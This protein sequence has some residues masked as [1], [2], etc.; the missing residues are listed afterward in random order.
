MSEQ[1]EIKRTSC[2]FGAG[3]SAAYGLPTL[4]QLPKA[5][6]EFIASCNSGYLKE[7]FELVKKIALE[8]H[9]KDLEKEWI[10]YEMLLGQLDY[11]IRNNSI[12]RVGEYLHGRESLQRAFTALT[13]IVYCTIDSKTSKFS[14]DKYLII[15]NER[16]LYRAFFDRIWSKTVNENRVPVISTISFNYDCKLDDEYQDHIWG[17]LGTESGHNIVPHYL[18]QLYTVS[19]AAHMKAGLQYKWSYSKHHELI[20][21]HG[22][23]D[24]YKCPNCKTIHNFKIVNSYSV[25]YDESE[26]L[27]D[28]RDFFKKLACGICGTRFEHELVAPILGKNENLTARELW[29]G[30]F[31]SLIEAHEIIVVGYSFPQSDLSFKYL[32]QH[33]LNWNTFRPKITVVDPNTDESY[34]NKVSEVFSLNNVEEFTRFNG[35]FS[36]YIDSFEK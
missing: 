2:I 6:V 5:I 11:F 12:I 15:S 22:S 28:Y 26:N 14:E 30:T 27:E 17:V 25:L 9:G 16:E 33:A 1:S 18:I 20:K 34:W 21:I 7:S 13:R 4:N 23:F 8:L 24:W 35:T 3:A 19:D 10:D 36:N 29:D 31:K 32:L